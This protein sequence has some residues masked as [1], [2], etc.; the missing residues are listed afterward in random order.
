[1]AAL[2]LIEDEVKRLVA[3]MK[4][5]LIV[6]WIFIVIVIVLLCAVG[7]QTYEIIQIQSQ[8]SASTVAQDL[9]IATGRIDDCRN[10][11]IGQQNITLGRAVQA[12]L[13]SQRSLYPALDQTI[14]IA[15][16]NLARIDALCGTVD[17]PKAA[18]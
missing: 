7:Y 15:D 9:I 16:T 1:M 8:Q 18:P 13:E 11:Y 10:T 14:A 17:H 12:I 3:G 6:L 5:R 2:D 4:R